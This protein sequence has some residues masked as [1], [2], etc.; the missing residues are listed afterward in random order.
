MDGRMAVSSRQLMTLVY[1]L[2]AEAR[3]L[4]LVGQIVVE[5]SLG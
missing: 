1:P 5:E 4:L 3:L 2:T